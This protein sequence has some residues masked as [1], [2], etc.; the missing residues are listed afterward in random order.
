[1]T[2]IRV[3]YETVELGP[4]DIH[5]RILRDNQQ[6]SDEDG[7]EAL[8]AGVSSAQ[9]PLFGLLWSS[10]RLLAERMAVEPLAGLRILEVGCGIGLTSLVLNRRAL[11]ITATDQHPR[12]GTFLAHNTDLNEDR[13]IPFVRAGWEEPCSALGLF[14]LVIGSDL[15]YESQQIVT[16]ASFISAHCRAIARVVIVDPG[17]GNLGRFARELEPHGFSEQTRERV[18]T[19]AF[20]GQI[21]TAWRRPA[22]P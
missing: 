20:Q 19:E 14:D 8:R 21:L 11:D 10:G 9:W 16:L 13:P 4:F 17:R 6:F 18:E 12:A 5:V 1:M 3:R 7:G 22:V 15:L 2:P